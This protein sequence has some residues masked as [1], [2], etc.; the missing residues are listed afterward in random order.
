M[1]RTVSNAI[2]LSIFNAPPLTLQDIP[3]FFRALIGDGRIS[4][5]TSSIIFPSNVKI[6]SMKI[7]SN[8]QKPASLNNVSKI[9]IHGYGLASLNT[10]NDTKISI[11]R[12]TG[13]Y[14]ELV[15]GNKSSVDI[16]LP[17]DTTISGLSN[18]KP[19]RFYNVSDI[20]GFN[21][22]PVRVYIKRALVNT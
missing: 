17:N 21:I 15:I 12:G 9:Q 22:G 11:S 6:T 13:L 16:F 10:T 7:T 18:N 1:L 2:N 5:A 14:S 19:F 4:M 20:S 3:A 8:H